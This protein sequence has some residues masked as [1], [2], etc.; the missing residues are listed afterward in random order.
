MREER[1]FMEKKSRKESKQK[2]EEISHR[3]SRD[4]ER[5]RNIK[6]QAEKQRK[7]AE[8]NRI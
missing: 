5:K 8:E 4:T 3:K 2:H 7:E 6:C 1:N